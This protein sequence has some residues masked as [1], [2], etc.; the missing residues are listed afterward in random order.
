MPAI[1][2]SASVPERGADQYFQTADP[3]LIQMAVRELVVA[4]LGRFQ[5]VWGGH[6]AITPMVWAVCEDLGIPYSER[7]ALYQ[8]ALLESDFPVENEQFG[9]VTVVPAVGQDLDRN[10]RRLRE[11]MLR[12]PGVEAGVFI[13]GMGGVEEEYHMMREMR[14]E[15]VRF[16]IAST[17][18]A[19]AVL[20]R[21]EEHTGVVFDGINFAAFFRR[22]FGGGPNLER[23][24]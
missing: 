16:V 8:T 13:G 23:E 24:E 5:I 15:A 14:P 4:A 1:F 17:G 10:L 6:P 21:R 19:A 11:A 9:N 7:F 20:G 22:A 3:F 18:G 12:H 2:L